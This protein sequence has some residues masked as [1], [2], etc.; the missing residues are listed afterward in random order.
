MGVGRFASGVV[1]LGE[2]KVRK[3]R[4]S[5]ADAHDAA[6]VSCTAVLPI[7]PLLDT[8][9]G[10]KAVVGVLDSMISHGVTFVRSVEL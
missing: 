7:A 1:R 9:R 10:F 4:G 5:A 3:V 6:D 2:H 8:R